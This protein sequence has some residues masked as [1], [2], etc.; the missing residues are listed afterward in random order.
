MS[1]RTQASS[2]IKAVACL[3]L[4]VHVKMLSENNTQIDYFMPVASAQPL[5]RRD[6]VDVGG[7]P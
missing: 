7:K 3:V 5:Y 1:K 6:E 2:I 4:H